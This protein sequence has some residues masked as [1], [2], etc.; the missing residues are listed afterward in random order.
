MLVELC[1]Y[2][3]AAGAAAGAAAA[4]AGAAAGAAGA[5]AEGAPAAALTAPAGAGGV[6]MP[7]DRRTTTRTMAA[8]GSAM[9]TPRPTCC[10]LV[11]LL[12][13]ATGTKL[14]AGVG[15]VAQ[16]EPLAHADAVLMPA[17]ARSVN[18][19]LSEVDT[20]DVPAEKLRALSK[21]MLLLAWPRA[22]AAVA[23]KSTGTV[24]RRT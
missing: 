4:A 3:A 11:R 10:E 19:M 9:P 16:L 12:D 22:P 20:A 2:T 24:M 6:A 21:R 17:K 18:G 15:R 8:S 7:R 23:G 14:G 13:A 5:A 1:A